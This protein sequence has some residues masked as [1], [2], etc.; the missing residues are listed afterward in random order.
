[1]VSCGETIIHRRDRCHA[2]PRMPRVP[3][4]LSAHAE[5]PAALL[6][7]NFEQ[8]IQCSCRDHNTVV[9][10]LVVVLGSFA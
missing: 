5:G 10:A 1:M 2:Y 4:Q 6:S 8:N 9:V 7:H 3:V